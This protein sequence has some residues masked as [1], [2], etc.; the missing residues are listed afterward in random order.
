MT[1]TT[2]SK[3]LTR[4]TIDLDF[5]QIRDLVLQMPDE[6]RK[7]IYSLLKSEFENKEIQWISEE[8]IDEAPEEE[9]EISDEAFYESLKEI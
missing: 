7:L 2:Q 8:L 4:L 5:T 3:P 1:L 9:T 6:E